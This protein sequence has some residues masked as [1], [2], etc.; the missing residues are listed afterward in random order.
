MSEGVPF[1][2]DL[3]WVMFGLVIF[4]ALCLIAIVLILRR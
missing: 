4:V 3:V 1:I 2:T